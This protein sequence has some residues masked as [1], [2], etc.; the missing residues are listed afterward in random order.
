MIT[1][2]GNSGRGLWNRVT[3]RLFP[4]LKFGCFGT[5]VRVT[6][7][8]VDESRSQDPKIQIW[9]QNKTQPGLYHKIG[10]DLPLN[11]PNSGSCYRITYNMNNSGLFQCTLNEGYRIAVQP[12]D[13][14]GLEIPP[15][16]D[17]DLEIY[18]KVGGS[19][20]L[21][22]QGLLNSTVNLS[23][24]PHNITNDEPQ[25]SFLVVLGKILYILS[26]ETSNLYQHDNTFQM[27]TQTHVHTLV[28]YQA[29][30][31]QLIS[32]QICQSPLRQN[33]SL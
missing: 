15:I 19:I 21:V 26:L 5:I 7:A 4:D 9:R 29:P 11:R 20:N 3:T 30:H 12:G 8:A 2:D 32:Q 25:I 1:R 24:V 18:F 28:A 6:A 10:P 14:L 33:L 16:N 27:K 17:D 22:F 23:N 13:F 31:Q